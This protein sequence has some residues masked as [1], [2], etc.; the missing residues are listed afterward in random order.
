MQRPVLLPCLNRGGANREGDE[1]GSGGPEEGAGG[2]D[3]GPIVADGEVGGERV[4]GGLDDGSE[5]GEGAEASGVGVEGGA[6][7]LIDPRQQGLV[8][9]L[10][11][12]SEIDQD[13]GRRLRSHHLFQI[14]HSSESICPPALT[15]TGHRIFVV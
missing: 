12:S 1:E 13:E 3:V 4:A 5:E 9:P 8:G 14:P 15:L 2:D 7:L 11:D 6:D 10:H